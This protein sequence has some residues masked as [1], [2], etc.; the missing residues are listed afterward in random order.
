MKRHVT[1]YRTI[2]TSTGAKILG[3]LNHGINELWVGGQVEVVVGAEHDDL[4][5]INGAQRFT[6]GLKFL[7]FPIEA[8]PHQAS[9]FVAQI[10]CWMSPSRHANHF[11]E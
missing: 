2:T 3:R 1:G 10:F 11:G 4:F 5:A 6:R 8:F 7:E 9:V